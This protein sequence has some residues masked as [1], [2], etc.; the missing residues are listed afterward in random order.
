MTRSNRFTVRSWKP[1]AAI[2]A[3]A[4]LISPLA[5]CGGGSGSSSADIPA[6][7]TDDG[8]KLTLW[9]RSDKE[10]QATNVAEAY[11]KSHK[12]Q[13]KVELVPSEDMEG[14]VGTSSQTD[15]LPD[16]LSGDVVRIPY[17][18][19]EGIFMDITEQIDGL[20]NKD[21]LQQGHI[22]AGTVDGAEYTLPFFTDQSVLVWN[23]DL[24]EQAGLDPDKGPSTVE[25]F[26]E[27]AKA[28]AD[29]GQDGVAG[30][31]VGGQCGGAAVFMTFPMIWASGEEVMNEDGTKALLDGG[32]SKAVFKMYRDL[33]NTKNGIGAGSQVENCSTWTT[34]FANG[35]IG[36]MPYA[37]A[38][39]ATLIEA[40]SK[41]GPHIGVSAIPGTKKGNGSSFLGGDAVGISKDS[42]NAA[43]AWN[44]LQ[45][46]TTEDAQQEAFADKGD[47]AS[48]LKVIENGYKDVDER[49]Q[50]ANGVLKN[51][52]T[53]VSPRF[54]EAFNASGSPWQI[55]L[56]DQIWGDS[57]KL[58]ADNQAI[59]DV[60]AQ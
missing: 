57:G 18:A 49:I 40:E 56:Q 28:V 30:T 2:A 14:K 50:I 47:T 37:G 41:G 43:Q 35:K 17:W 20:D 60:L 48:N 21:D 31:Y 45:W 24:Y 22:D 4:M 26:Y 58:K 13:I 46:L 3:A 23:K 53:P 44:F 7:G 10:R 33:A 1:L 42:K 52:R 36:V 54:N 19:S 29:L 59:T 15:S 25:E 51:G 5:A 12:N 16:L 39:V 9:V 32:A 27:Q 6:G 38:S 55:L 8:T 11:N 34:P